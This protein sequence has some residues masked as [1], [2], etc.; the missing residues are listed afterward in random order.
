[1]VEWWTPGL[2]AVAQAFFVDR[3]GPDGAEAFALWKAQG[4]DK[5]RLSNITPTR[6]YG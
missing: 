4:G 1:M 2:G 6:V 3:H 5:A